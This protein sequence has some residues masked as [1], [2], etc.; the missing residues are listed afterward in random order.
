MSILN[1][2]A[3]TVGGGRFAQMGYPF[4]GRSSEIGYDRIWVGGQ[5][6][7]GPKKSDILYGRPLTEILTDQRESNLKY[8]LNSERARVL[9][10]FYCQVFLVFN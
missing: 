7:K 6:K 9:L 3:G 5:V 2:I 4:L 1:T 8:S 10:T